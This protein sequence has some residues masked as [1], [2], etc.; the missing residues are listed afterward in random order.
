MPDNDNSKNKIYENI[1]GLTETLSQLGLYKEQK[2]STE[3]EIKSLKSILKV[4]SGIMIS[5]FILVVI[6]F[7][8]FVIDAIYFHITNNK[9][10]EN[11]NDCRQN[12]DKI[13]TELQL[14]KAKHPEFFR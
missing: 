14:L 10:F 1:S 8:G 7:M 2:V 6:A 5:V 12:T 13:N 9:Y 11:A 4:H 3:D